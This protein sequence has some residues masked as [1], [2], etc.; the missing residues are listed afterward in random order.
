[1][2]TPPALPRETLVGL[3][4]LL[5]ILASLV[6]RSAPEALTPA[7]QDH[8]VRAHE[9]GLRFYRGEMIAK[10]FLPDPAL[11]WSHLIADPGTVS[12]F[13]G[14]GVWAAKG[15]L[16]GDPDK[17]PTPPNWIVLYV[18]EQ[19]QTLFVRVGNKATGDPQAALR[20]A[21]VA[22]GSPSGAP[23]EK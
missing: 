10:Q 23:L 13:V 9:M 4:I 15:T 8:I 11:H 17:V 14:N 20:R 2:K 16:S 1:M 6:Y 21:G 5:V 18:P 7:M 12:I 19:Q 3:L 22:P